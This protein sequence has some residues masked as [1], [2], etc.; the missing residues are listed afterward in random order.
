MNGFPLLSLSL[1]SLTKW[2]S[3][4]CIAFTGLAGLVLGNGRLDFR[5][6]ALF[7]GLLFL[8][9][10]GSSINQMQDADFDARLERTR[11]R[12]IPRKAL[13][14]AQAVAFGVTLV[15][16]GAFIL[17][18]ILPPMVGLLGL[19]GIFVYNG[20]YTPLKR[21]TGFAIFPGVVA[22]CIPPLMG[23]IVAGKGLDSALPW[24]LVGVGCFWQL[25]HFALLI[26][27]CEHDYAAH[28]E[29][30]SLLS[31]LSRSGL[32]GV[33]G[34]GALG[35]LLCG[36]G[37]V[38]QSVS[39]LVSPGSIFWLTLLVAVI[40]AREVL[41]ARRNNSRF[42]VFRAWNILAGE[43]LVLLVLWGTGRS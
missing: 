23:L 9:A 36:G 27:A 34:I 16:I 35:T 30:P 10:G 28:P 18:S 2:Y 19:T 42:P 40:P 26:W 39:P 14:A 15:G 38:Y 31:A 20:V 25:T 3:S 7:L 24:L 13:T 22:G 6:G 29:I 17:F 21:C 4:L 1:L 11:H 43:I 5:G 41:K 12:P 33:M 37:L 8:A 32:F